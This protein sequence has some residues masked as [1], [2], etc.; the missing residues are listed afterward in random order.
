[1]M[2][3]YGIQWVD[4]VRYKKMVKLYK[5]ED[6]DPKKEIVL[7]LRDEEMNDVLPMKLMSAFSNIVELNMSRNNIIRFDGEILFQCCRKL[8]VINFDHNQLR[9]LLDFVPLGKLQHITSLSLLHNPVTDRKEG[10]PLIDELLFPPSLKRPNIVEIFTATY[11]HVPN[12]KE[13]I[14][15]EVIDTKNFIY[16]EEVA[17][18]GKQEFLTSQ[19][20]KKPIALF[21]ETRWALQYMSKPCP[22][23]KVGLYR[24]LQTLNGKQITMFDVLII[25]G[26][27]KSQEIVA[28]ELHERTEAKLNKNSKKSGSLYNASRP[29]ILNK[30]TTEYVIANT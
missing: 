16:D 22:K 26:A 4:V 8:Q 9:T 2:Q 3:H 11:T 19:R 6:Y 28:E 23:R 13:F 24:N 29:A 20:I 30:E 18:M 25:T 17:R 7:D 12:P 21:K 10:L 15:K 5:Q 27:Q 1:M 14:K